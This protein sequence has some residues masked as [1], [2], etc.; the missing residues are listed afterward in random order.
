MKGNKRGKETDKLLLEAIRRY[1]G[2]SQYELAEKLGW[3]S[4]HVD[5][6][7]RRLVKSKKAFLRIIERDGRRVNLVY[8]EEY[9]PS[10][11]IEVPSDLLEVDNPTWSDK[12]F[13]YALDS[14]TIGVSGREVDEWREMSCFTESTPITKDNEKIVF[15]IPE[16]FWRFYDLDGKHR[17]VSIN[18]NNLLITVSGYIVEDKKY[19]S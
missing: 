15:K 11:L 7:V 16:R 4:G 17:V 13:L 19:P 8:P 2:L 3:R 12:A 1:P 6:S 14:S 9:K 10:N 5:G 18:G